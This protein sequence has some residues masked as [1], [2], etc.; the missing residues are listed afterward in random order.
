MTIIDK[1]ISRKRLTELAQNFYGEMIKGVVDIDRQI[2]ALDAELHSDLEKLLLENG[3]NQESLWGINLYPDVEGDDFIE[4]DSLINISPR[5]N[6]FSRN[7]EDEAIRGQIRS[8]VNN[9]IK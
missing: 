5:R 8:I 7:V 4:F 6:N 1:A 2:M 3:S 9:L